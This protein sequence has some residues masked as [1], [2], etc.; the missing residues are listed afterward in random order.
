MIQTNLHF[1]GYTMVTCAC[2]IGMLTIVHPSLHELYVIFIS[3]IIIHEYVCK[4]QV[5]VILFIMTQ[6]KDTRYV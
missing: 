4:P 1:T 2:F 5:L 6:I 3:C